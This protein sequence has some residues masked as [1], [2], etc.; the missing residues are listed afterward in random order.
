MGFRTGFDIK[1]S[2]HEVAGEKIFNDAK[3]PEGDASQ[4]FDGTPKPL[5][6]I[7]RPG[8]MFKL[9]PGRTLLVSAALNRSHQALPTKHGAALEACLK[10]FASASLSKKAS[11]NLTKNSSANLSQTKD[12][13][14]DACME[15]VDSQSTN[16]T[17][18][19]SLPKSSLGPPSQVQNLQMQIDKL[20]L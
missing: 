12:S 18:S 14:S 6:V 19:S 13:S 17:A 1:N 2:I 20:K 9:P 11:V 8:K 7:K 10:E 15:E 16:D 4:K 3:K 5:R